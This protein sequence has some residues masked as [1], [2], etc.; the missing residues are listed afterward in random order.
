M[1]GLLLS[2]F[3]GIVT[4]F[5]LPD[6]VGNLYRNKGQQPPVSA[7]TGFW[8]FIPLIGGIIWLFKVQGRLNDFWASAA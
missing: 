5:L 1:L 8:C 7:M 6:E 2:F 3:C 4:I